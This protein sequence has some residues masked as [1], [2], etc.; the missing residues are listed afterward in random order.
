MAQ[1]DKDVNETVHQE[2]II[3]QTTEEPVTKKPVVEET[4]EEPIVKEPVSEPEVPETNV[5]VQTS[6]NHTDENGRVITRRNLFIEL[7]KNRSRNF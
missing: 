6:S 4:H 2:E 5:K 3:V 7:R 1:K